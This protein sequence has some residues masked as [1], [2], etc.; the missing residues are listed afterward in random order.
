MCNR[1]QK[2]L[3]SEYSD[4]E[5]TVLIESPFAE[6]SRSGQGIRQ[7]QI[8]LTPTKLILA[9]YSVKT[10]DGPFADSQYTGNVDPDIDSFEIIKAYPVDCVNLSV[11]HH[12]KRKTLKASFCNGNVQFF[13]IGGW[14]ERKRLWTVWCERI[15]FLSPYDSAS[16]KSETSVASFSSGSSIFVVKSNL[17]SMSSGKTLMWCHYSFSQPSLQNSWA[18]PHL[19]LG[20]EFLNKGV[21]CSS[22]PELE[23]SRSYCSEMAVIRQNFSE[24]D[25]LRLSDECEIMARDCVVLWE[26]RKPLLRKVRRKYG[27]YPF[28]N[29]THGLGI[30]AFSKG[31]KFS[32]QVKR[33]NS[34]V[35][36]SYSRLRNA[37]KYSRLQRTI[38]HEHLTAAAI[39]PDKLFQ[40]TD[41]TAPA[42]GIDFWT[43]GGMH[44]LSWSR[45]RYWSQ[46]RKLQTIRKASFTSIH[47][48]KTARKKKRK[49]QSIS[50]F[51]VNEK[52]KKSIISLTNEACG[53]GNDQLEIKCKQEHFKK[54]ST[55]GLAR[56]LT[57]LDT[58]L[59]LQIRSIEAG[60]ICKDNESFR[61]P[62]F[63]AALSFS[64]RITSLVASTVISGTNQRNR[65]LSIVKF[66][67]VAYH[68]HK[69][70]SVQST[71]N[72]LRGLQT[73]AVFR[74][75]DTWE[76]VRKHHA[77]KYRRF[78]DLSRR[79]SDPRLPLYQRTFENASEVPPYLPSLEL[80]AAG[81][82]DRLVAFPILK[83]PNFSSKCPSCSRSTLKVNQYP[84]SL[85]RL[86]SLPTVVTNPRRSTPPSSSRCSS[87]FHLHRMSDDQLLQNL[88][89]LFTPVNSS[90]P[91][92]KLLENVEFFLESSH[93]AAS[94]YAFP[95]NAR[96]RSFLALSRYHELQ[97]SFSLSMQLEP[98]KLT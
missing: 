96:I 85:R 1:I 56:Q 44:K 65:A 9:M 83:S 11:Y 53:D 66:V 79:Y 81:L 20:P 88:D 64:Q 37:E 43:P 47:S 48:Q 36:L 76:Y 18:D 41:S 49:R 95:V 52:S 23:K 17:L 73:P 69:L 80:L 71:V 4:L 27:I 33:S 38:S 55:N 40:L 61:A 19:Y 5:D 10:V 21:N 67:G 42:Q 54:L 14:D 91:V 78:E 25:V 8:G 84:M 39:C 2:L 29:L 87:D 3:F 74:L 59:F 63:R 45:E 16:S 46:Q 97:E 90:C 22:L 6:T 82:L 58:L 7:V 51:T 98:T 28:P 72:I 57:M 86:D 70:N 68:C 31:D 15:K 93:A 12:K 32:L 62:Y 60:R 77:S 89:K 24:R 26:S 30:W 75:Q 50:I 13:E 92:R 35:C 34:E 94:L